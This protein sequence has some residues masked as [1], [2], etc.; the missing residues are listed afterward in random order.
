MDIQVIRMQEVRFKFHVS[1]S[2]RK[3]DT[4]TIGLLGKPA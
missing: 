4:I 3:L 1:I 2:G